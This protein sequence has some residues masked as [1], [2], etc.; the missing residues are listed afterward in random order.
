MYVLE[1]YVAL[2][3]LAILFSPNPPTVLGKHTLSHATLV[4]PLLLEP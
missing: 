3:R 2:I 4:P 1:L